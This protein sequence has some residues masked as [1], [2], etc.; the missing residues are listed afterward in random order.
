MLDIR[1]DY[2]LSLALRQL[3]TGTSEDR[4][5]TVEL[6]ILYHQL[7][8][9]PAAVRS[10]VVSHI[11]PLLKSDDYALRYWA[12]RA[13]GEYR[14]VGALQPLREALK[15]ERNQSVRGWMQGAIAH[16]S[17][18][19]VDD[20]LSDL[21]SRDPETRAL[22][23]QVLFF[24][25]SPHAREIIAQH[26]DD[27]ELTVLPWKLLA[28]PGP[29]HMLQRAALL[30]EPDSRWVQAS[31]GRP[32]LLR[33]QRV[34]EFLLSLLSSGDNDVT[35]FAIWNLS[36]GRVEDA[37]SMIQQIA[38]SS[39][40]LSPRVRE[41]AYKYLGFVPQRH[42]LPF[43][44]SALQTEVDP[45]AREG[46]VFAMGRIATPAAIEQLTG[47]LLSDPD[48]GVRKWSARALG[49]V[50][51]AG[52]DLESFL[53]AA[54]ETERSHR[55]VREIYRA[56]QTKGTPTLLTRL[57]LL[58]THAA[59]EA[60]QNEVISLLLALASK[61]MSIDAKNKLLELLSVVPSEPSDLLDLAYRMAKEYGLMS[62]FPAMPPN[63]LEFLDTYKQAV[64][65]LFEALTS[66]GDDP[67]FAEE[68]ISQARELL[69][70]FRTEQASEPTERQSILGDLP[71]LAHARFYEDLC[72][73]Y[74]EIAQGI[75]NRLMN[76]PGLSQKKFAKAADFFELHAQ[77]L[78]LPAT[79][80]N[81][82]SALNLWLNVQCQ[83]N[84]IAQA[85][86]G[87]GP[88]E[89]EIFSVLTA[90]I[91]RAKDS[92][93]TSVAIHF[94]KV[95]QAIS[96][97]LDSGV[98][99]PLYDRHSVLNR[100]LLAVPVAIEAPFDVNN[101]AS[102]TLIQVAE[103]HHKMMLEVEVR[104]NQ[105]LVSQI[106]LPFDLILAHFSPFGERLLE[107]V[108]VP[109][110]EIME[111]SEARTLPL[112]LDRF[113]IPTNTSRV[114]LQPVLRFR[115][116]EWPAGTPIEVIAWVSDSRDLPAI[117]SHSILRERIIERFD[118]EEIRTLCQDL[119]V[120]FDSLRG[121]GK[122]AKARELVSYMSRR[123][124]LRQLVEALSSDLGYDD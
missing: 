91:L 38:R 82:C 122:A 94:G 109:H 20:V 110:S 33:L 50:K 39:E 88:S 84:F 56:L 46:I 69:H 54:L 19:R 45:E 62:R 96:S 53:L 90:A 99:A 85:H 111:Y 26:L 15:T 117:P 13:L 108:L 112:T 114:E 71:V 116:F 113:S 107:F 81:L 105:L 60:Y 86:D 27:P 115:D 18:V 43:L 40:Y 44:I 73:A 103:T 118:I 35:E 68:S 98:I 93:R 123:S 74:L 9:V 57:P 30:C 28:I 31:L 61:R 22:A 23:A 78:A 67:W 47:A 119:D 80:R 55:V 8:S 2:F 37:L 100:W 34:R 87:D 106:R 42:S 5:E 14:S 3:S 70:L 83:M 102:V 29:S 11:A 48:E 97:I 36:L 1:T 95:Q 65:R 101:C 10:E 59:S 52:R 6:L 63:S 4:K 17:K 21:Q 72:S 25:E 79:E 7:Y 41:W 58:E 12:A 32:N 77:D 24:D 92:L 89:A 49:N 66:Y 76:K 16:L 51:T 120:D 104:I 121:E 124:R 64:N 75:E